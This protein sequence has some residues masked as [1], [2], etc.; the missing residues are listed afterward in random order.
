MGAPF[1][2]HPPLCEVTDLDWEH[3]GGGALVG[4]ERI[5]G[6]VPREDRPW[7]IVD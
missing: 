3:S 5:T 1:E 6:A 4:H 2:Y 7:L